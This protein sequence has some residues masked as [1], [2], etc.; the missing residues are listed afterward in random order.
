MNEKTILGVGVGA[1]IGFTG[2]V[3]YNLCKVNKDLLKIIKE[4]K[5]FIGELVK[6]V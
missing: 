1:L 5:D 4:Q 6:A 2:I 3:T